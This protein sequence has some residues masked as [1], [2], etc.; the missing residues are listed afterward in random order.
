MVGISALGDLTHLQLSGDLNIVDGELQIIEDTTDDNILFV[1]DV[2]QSADASGTTTYNNYDVG[3]DSFNNENAVL[4]VTGESNGYNLTG[5]ANGYDGRIFYFYNAQ[6][7]NVT[8]FNLN[9]GSNPEN[10]IITSSGANEGINGEGVAEFIYDGVQ[11]KWIL[12]NLRS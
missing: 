5:F 7:N 2:D 11:Q 9:P 4:R 6:G 10:Q 12:I 3:V 8:F 1:G